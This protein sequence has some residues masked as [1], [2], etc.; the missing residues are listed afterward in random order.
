MRLTAEL[1]RGP[2]NTFPV[3]SVCRGDK[4]QR[5]DL[6]VNIGGLQVREGRLPIIQT[7]SVTDSAENC[8]GPAEPLERLQAETRGFILDKHC[9]DPEAIGQFGQRHKRS[10]RIFRQR[11]MKGLNSCG[12]GR[13]EKRRPLSVVRRRVYDILNS[14]NRVHLFPVFL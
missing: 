2:C 4:V 6:P 1:C 9:F 3:I 14:L 13:A 5:C 10:P 11:F 7:Q 12:L 8:I